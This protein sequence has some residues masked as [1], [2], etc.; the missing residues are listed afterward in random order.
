M[1]VDFVLGKSSSKRT[2]V[3]DLEYR[4]ENF[5]FLLSFMRRILSIL[6]L[7]AELQQGIFNVVEAGGWWFA[8][9]SGA[10]WRHDGGCSRCEI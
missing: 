4:P 10:D 8:I 2:L 1:F 5:I 3:T 9:A 6:H 7:I